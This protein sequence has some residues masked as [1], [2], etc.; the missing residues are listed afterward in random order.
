MRRIILLILLLLLGTNLF[1]VT[2]LGDI[3]A[4]GNYSREVITD[5][6]I[7]HTLT[8]YITGVSN[9]VVLRS[10]GSLDGTNWFYLDD[11]EID[12]TISANGTY[13]EHKGN[14]TCDK[15]RVLFVSES[16][17]GTPTINVKYMGK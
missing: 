17:G 13:M 11:L 8:Y 9:N 10:E 3:T 14:F 1:A 7:N 16:G 5:L 6:N 2:D 15:M 12:W 4:T